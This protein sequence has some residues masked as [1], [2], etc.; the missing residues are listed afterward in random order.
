M[1]IFGKNLRFLGLC[2]AMT[3]SLIAHAD[4]NDTH[5]H[6]NILFI[7]EGTTWNVEVNHA[8]IPDQTP[9]QVSQRLEGTETVNGQEYLKLL[10]KIE[11]GEEKLAS[12]V[13]LDKRQERIYALDPADVERGER[14]VY[15]FK[16]KGIEDIPFAQ[17]NW[18]GTLD[19]R[20]YRITVKET[21]LV[22]NC[23]YDYSVYEVSIYPYGST[24]N[25][26]EKI[27]SCEWIRGIG[28]VAGFANQ[29]YPL[30]KDYTTTLKSVVTSCQN[31]LV[32]EKP[33]VIIND[34]KVWNYAMSVASSKV[35]EYEFSMAFGETAKLGDKY[36]HEF[37]TNKVTGYKQFA[38]C[39]DKVSEVDGVS[40]FYLR[41]EGKK[42]YIYNRS[43]GS[44]KF[45]DDEGMPDEFLLYDFSLDT[46]DGYDTYSG[47]N[48]LVSLE[49]DDIETVTSCGREWRK[50]NFGEIECEGRV[51]SLCAVEGVGF[52]SGVLGSTLVYFNDA[53]FTMD[54]TG[55]DAQYLPIPVFSKVG[56]VNVTDRDG[57]VLFD[58]EE[59]GFNFNSVES[60]TADRLTLL[61]ANGIVTA[62]S[63]SG[64]EVRLT[65]CGIDGTVR[66]DVT[67][68]GEATVNISA[69][70]RGIY[71]VHATDG[72]AVKVVKIA[73]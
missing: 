56:L 11:G 58:P 19:S 10:T 34:N 37:K 51:S 8:D 14:L 22:R 6:N 48:R 18:D 62:A 32:Y 67:G 27:A 31:G 44:E 57:N 36:Y 21:D 69:L 71:T 4:D 42:V 28:S 16:S 73:H 47:L 52:L 25:A 49:A 41:E 39:K 40:A 2:V 7:E 70:G 45:S 12:Y 29:L 26:D 61:S 23:G 24:E 46:G 1:K 68:T 17:L 33:G 55:Q 38:H 35:S 20:D 65:V 43:Y 60:V 53:A 50:F 64:S 9:I 72:E 30:C 15:S 63:E 5:P 66:A 13:R 54:W 3:G 59:L